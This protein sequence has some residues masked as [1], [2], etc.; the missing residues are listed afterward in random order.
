[1]YRLGDVLQV[2]VLPNAAPTSSLRSSGANHQ[3]L[4]HTLTHALRWCG[5]WNGLT[6]QVTRRL[7]E[8]GEP[9]VSEPERTARLAEEHDNLRA[10]LRWAEESREPAAGETGRAM[11][12]ERTIEDL[13]R[14]TPNRTASERS[15]RARAQ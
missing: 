9:H 13:F 14:D 12:L 4:T 15:R 8:D 3:T 5:S 11:T 10:A 6:L 2:V 7:A 1:V